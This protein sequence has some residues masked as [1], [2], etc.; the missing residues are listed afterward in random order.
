MKST[1]HPQHS[2]P[3][4]VDVDTS[5]TSYTSRRSTR[6]PVPHSTD[7]H[8]GVSSTSGALKNLQDGMYESEQRRLA[9]VEKL[10]EAHE[11]LQVCLG[12]KSVSG[13]GYRNV[14][15]PFQSRVF[16]IFFNHPP[17]KKKTKTKKQN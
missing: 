10:R 15:S 8:W 5:P 11:T 9:L 12:I 4:H 6:T 13:V 7:E 2:S 17:P 14:V 1:P 16:L 3:I